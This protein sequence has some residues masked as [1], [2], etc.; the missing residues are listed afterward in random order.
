[1]T[2]SSKVVE[3]ALEQG[4]GIFR[5]FPNWVPR[6]FCIPGKRLK[7]HPDDYYAFGAHRGGIDERWFAST[8][9]ADN[10]PETLPDEG[11]SYIYFKDGRKEEKVLLKEAIDIMGND[12]LGTDVMK[13]YGG[14]LMFSKFFDN[15]EP[16]PHHLHHDDEAAANVGAM[17]KPESYYFPAQLNNHGGWFPYTFFGLNPG[18]TKDDIRKCLENWNK[19]D[20]GILYLSRAYKLKPG[21]GWDVPPGVLHA[22]GSL[23]TY[24]PQRSSDVFAMFQSLVW[25]VPTPWELLTKN[26]PEE[27]KNDLDYIVSLI[28]WDLNV[29]PDFYQNRFAEPKL[30]KP[31]EEMKSEGYEEY[32]ISYK[33]SD[34]SAKELRVFPGKTVTIKDEG[35]YG[36]ITIEG[37]GQF[38]SLSIDAPS[39]IRFGEMTSD[40]LFVTQKAAREGITITNQSENGMLVILKHFGP[41]L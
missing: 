26:V 1:M 21:T 7:L 29:D 3:K 16:L 10:G 8:T 5:L 33:S 4:K 6:S 23:L 37:H 32:W 13:K 41:E 20:N 14:W 11:L 17:G 36:L 30:V 35:A 18:T 27:H 39:L 28:N 38:G 2:N 22:P 25:D 34:F 24:E 19:G 40:E 15:M 12:I 31:V 9:K